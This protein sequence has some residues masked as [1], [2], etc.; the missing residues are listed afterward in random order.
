MLQGV[1]RWGL[2]AAVVAPKQRASARDVG[3]PISFRLRTWCL[4][5]L[6]LSE[7]APLQRS[8]RRLLPQ[9]DSYGLEALVRMKSPSEEMRGTQEGGRMEDA[10]AQL[11]RGLATMPQAP[12]GEEV[13][14]PG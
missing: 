13:F 6:C 7:Q 11:Q 14:W 2:L 5:F 4:E 8:P 10:Q 1:F 9:R 12:R 3:A